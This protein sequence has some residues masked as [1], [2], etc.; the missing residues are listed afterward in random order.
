[1][2]RPVIGVV[3]APGKSAEPPS[4]A[5]AC[6]TAAD[7]GGTAQSAE[8]H[9]R[10]VGSAYRIFATY[11][12]LALFAASG[13]A[14]SADIDL[15]AGDSVTS[16]QRSTPVVA[17]G[18][19]GEIRQWQGIAFQPE[20]GLTYVASRRHQGADFGRGAWVAAAGVRFPEITHHLFFSFQVGV[21]APQTPALSST[22][23][24]VSSLGWSHRHVVIELRHISNGST[25]APNLGETML[26]AGIV[27]P[28]SR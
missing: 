6:E 1:M 7:G 3:P 11:L 18:W 19:T 13:A 22:Q 5:S 14:R 20:L 10:T 24:F 27:L 25:R 17:G 9:V 26:L 21:A 23:Q 16:G 15:M 28:M 2:P 4:R 12:F 8:R